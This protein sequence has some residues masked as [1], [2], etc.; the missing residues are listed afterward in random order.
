MS[1]SEYEQYERD[2][3]NSDGRVSSPMGSFRLFPGSGFKQVPYVVR[4]RDEGHPSDVFNA[5]YEA[6]RH[7]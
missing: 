5:D 2:R 1:P 6:P 3:D 7:D 4:K